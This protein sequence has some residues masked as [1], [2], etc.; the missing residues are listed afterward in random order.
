MADLYRLVRESDFS[1]LRVVE[2]G[3]TIYVFARY[4]DRVDV[5][6]FG[7]SFL[8]EMKGRGVPGP[9]LIRDTRA[10]YRVASGE[11]SCEGY[12]YRGRCKHSDEVAEWLSAS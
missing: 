7:R 2:D 1:A 10:D 5:H 11:C 4:P 6:K 3:P 12:Q 9:A 8:A